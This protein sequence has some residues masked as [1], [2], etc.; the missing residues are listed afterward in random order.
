MLG[1]LQK[2]S[3]TSAIEDTVLQARESLAADLPRLKALAKDEAGV[4]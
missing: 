4:A 2:A 1:S 3:E